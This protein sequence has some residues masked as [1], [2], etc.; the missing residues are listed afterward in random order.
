MQKLRQHPDDKAALEALH[1]AIQRCKDEA[2]QF[3]EKVKQKCDEAWR[4]E[5]FEQAVRRLNG[6]PQTPGEPREE[7]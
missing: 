2:D 3:K 4:L 1:R 6:L 5:Q 7:M